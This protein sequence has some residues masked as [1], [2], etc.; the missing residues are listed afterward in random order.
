MTLDLNVPKK[1]MG[2]KPGTCQIQIGEVLGRSVE[3]RDA[4]GIM[5]G[6]SLEE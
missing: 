6:T 1:E 4:R 5:T 3:D 2:S